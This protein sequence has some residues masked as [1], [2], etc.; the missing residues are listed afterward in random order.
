MTVSCL[1]VSWTSL[2]RCCLAIRHAVLPLTF[3]AWCEFACLW[4]SQSQMDTLF[5]MLFV[6]VLLCSRCMMS[7]G[8]VNSGSQLDKL[9]EVPFGDQVQR[10]KSQS[11]VWFVYV[12]LHCCLSIAKSHWSSA[13]AGWKHLSNSQERV[14]C[15]TCTPCYSGL[16]T[17]W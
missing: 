1:A 9:V 16:Q 13:A 15:C 12:L 6:D 11:S 5:E 4:F 10:S 3:L 8:Q 2:L 17:T 14:P 7:S